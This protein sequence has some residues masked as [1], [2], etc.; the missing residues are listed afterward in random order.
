MDQ[1]KVF[2]RMLDVIEDF[3]VPETRLAVAHG[4]KIFGAAI[5]RRSDLSLVVA[6]TNHEGWNPLWHGE[7]YTIK[8]FFELSDHPDPKECIFLSTH[9][10]CSMCLSS[11]AWS[12]FP[13]IYFLFGYEQTRDAF[14]IP[15][16]IQILNEVFNC[17]KP[18]RKNKFFESFSLQEMVSQLS[19]PDLAKARLEKLQRIYNELSDVYQAGEKKMI[20][21]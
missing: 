17:P 9:E 2:W 16:D 13:Q 21:K 15:Y 6:G 19:E 8:K 14:N 20:L 18:S 4:H 10:P 1:E 12:G 7:V 5:L 11:I 3:I